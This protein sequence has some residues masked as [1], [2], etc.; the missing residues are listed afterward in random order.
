MGIYVRF[1]DSEDSKLENDNLARA[2]CEAPVP[3][4]WRITPY[5]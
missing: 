4:H 3:H 2:A 1:D 5:T